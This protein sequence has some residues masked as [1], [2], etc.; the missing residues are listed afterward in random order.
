MA[1]GEG[2]GEAVGGTRSWI[3]GFGA[4]PEGTRPWAGPQAPMAAG[5]ALK[6]QAPGGGLGAAGPARGSP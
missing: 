5:R 2:N 6:G 4:F 1:A 3:W